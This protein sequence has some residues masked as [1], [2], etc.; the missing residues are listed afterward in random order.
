VRAARHLR[1]GHERGG[2]T[3]DEYFF[4]TY[5][6]HKIKEGDKNYLPYSGSVGIIVTKLNLLELYYSYLTKHSVAAANAAFNDFNP[7]C[8][9]ISDDTLKEA[10]VFRAAFKAKHRRSNISFVDCIGY[11]LAKKMKVK[12]LTGDK[13][14]EGVENVEFVK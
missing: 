10:A 12:F 5:A 13:E 3:I 1:T 2:E 11:I 9:G 8:I 6:L 14:F 7:F 4:D